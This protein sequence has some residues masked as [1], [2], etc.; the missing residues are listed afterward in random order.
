MPPLPKKAEEL[1]QTEL[2]LFVNRIQSIEQPE[3]LENIYSQLKN[4]V[5]KP[6]K[7]ARKHR[8]RR[9]KQFWSRRLDYLKSRRSK[10]YRQASQAPVQQKPEL[11]AQYRGLD[12]QIR[13]LIQKNKRKSRNRLTEA[14]SSDDPHER[15]KVIKAALKHKNGEEAENSVS[16]LD[17]A[18]FTR[19]VAT[20]PGK[21]H[22]P[23]IVPFDM[24]THL[25][26]KVFGAI[27]SAKNNKATGTDELFNEAFKITPPH[28]AKI[29]S[30][31]W[32][33]CSHLR[34]LLRDWRTALL[35]P[36][37]KRGPKNEPSSYRP[38]ALLSHGRQMISKAIGA[39]IRTEYTF[40]PTQLGFR[41]KAG[42]ETAL[43][44]HAAST[45]KGFKY[46]AVLDLKGAYPSVP[47]D[48]LMEKV[49]SKLSPQTA[50][51]IALELQPETITT[52]GDISGTTA[53]V[54]LGVPQGGSS[55]PPLYNIEMDSFCEMMESARRK[56]TK[57]E[58]VDVSAFADDVKLRARTAAGLQGALD[59][60]SRWADQ[61]DM[62]WG[63]PKCHVL[64]P[65]DRDLS[66]SGNLYFIGGEEI[67]IADSASYLGV[68]LRG[69]KI[70]IDKNLDRIKSAMQRIGTLKAAGIHRKY[71]TSARLVEICRTH[72]YP[73]AEYAIHLMPIDAFCKCPLSKKLELLDYKVV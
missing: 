4:L 59:I 48:K 5:L 15:S 49:N 71:T 54:T 63:P 12:R 69:T 56:S 17:L 42:T 65:E 34:Y 23:P 26:R 67:H 50:A 6:R 28:F 18:S 31:L 13:S 27:M 60:C 43:I 16:E 1:Y 30:L 51:M 68:T 8:P 33:Q 38:I 47:R 41:E 57:D 62:S 70:D 64:E 61:E 25:E 11:W 21:G 55:S 20:P 3:D 22:I 7:P 53:T 24:S 52:K 10:K 66:Q 9:Y 46:T 39:M 32:V 44:R 45:S 72:V 36:I 2:P 73:L 40:H 58:E 35:V 37:Y 14:L 19:S 29:L